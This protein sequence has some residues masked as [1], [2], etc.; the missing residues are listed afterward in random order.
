LSV[1]AIPVSAKLVFGLVMVNVREVVPFNGICAAP[2]ALVMDGGVATVKLAVAVLP[3]PP[4]VEV[5]FPVV[6]VY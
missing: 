4:F 5:T 3:V 1:K 2:K 6:L